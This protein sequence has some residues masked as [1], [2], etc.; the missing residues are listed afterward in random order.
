[1]NLPVDSLSTTHNAVL[2]TATVEVT[3][4]N[5]LTLEEQRERLH[6]ERDN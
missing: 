3:A 1:M 5:E 4:S 6:L 2:S